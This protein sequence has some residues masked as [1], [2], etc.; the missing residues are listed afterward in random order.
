MSFFLSNGLGPLPEAGEG[1]GGS[2]IVRVLVTAP[3]HLT[4]S[5]GSLVGAGNNAKIQLVQGDTGRPLEF[6]VYDANNKPIPLTGATAVF[7]MAQIGGSKL[8]TGAASL[9]ATEEFGSV[10]R[11]AL[12]S[13]GD[14]TDTPGLYTV[15]LRITWSDGTIQTL[16]DSGNIVAEIR[17][18]P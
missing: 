18:S 7:R 4:D 8:V 13:D 12:S 2:G 10:F 1:D 5:D 16:P 9:V 14:D 15:E 17:P 6:K 11:Y 3:F